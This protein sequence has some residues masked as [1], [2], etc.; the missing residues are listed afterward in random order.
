M[1]DIGF[2]LFDFD[3]IIRSAIKFHGGGKAFIK[4]ITRE[5]AKLALDF[6]RIDGVSAVVPRTVGD[7]GDQIVTKR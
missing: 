7:E 1:L 4:G 3:S 2:F 6:R 5:K